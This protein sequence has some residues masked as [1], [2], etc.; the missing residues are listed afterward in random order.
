[1]VEEYLTY[2]PNTGE[3]VWI[4]DKGRARAGDLAGSFDF[5]GY[6]IIRLN[7][8]R[9]KAHRL[10]WYLHYGKWPEKDIDHVNRNK[11]DNR[12]ENLREVSARENASNTLRFNKGA[13]FDK[14][15][16]KWRASAVLGGK[17]KNLGRFTTQGEAQAAYSE[18]IGD[19]NES[20]RN[21]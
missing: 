15:R 9:Y 18:A 16:G 20:V 10:A 13:Y 3:I 19:K 7:G 5:Y 14:E 11:S 8:V 6:L 1:M 17:S 2:N 4:K 21:E 12:I